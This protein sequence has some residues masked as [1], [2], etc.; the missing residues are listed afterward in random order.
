MLPGIFPEAIPVTHP[1]KR[2]TCVYP[3]TNRN[4]LKLGL[5]DTRCFAWVFQERRGNGKIETINKM[6][7]KESFEK[8]PSLPLD[9]F[10]NVKEFLLEEDYNNALFTSKQKLEYKCHVVL[11]DIIFKRNIHDPNMMS[12]FSV[13]SGFGPVPL[14]ELNFAKY[15]LCTKGN[16]GVVVMNVLNATIDALHG[17]KLHLI[18]NQYL[19]ASSL[20]QIWFRELESE[21]NFILFILK[22]GRL[23]LSKVPAK[24]KNNVSYFLKDMGKYSSEHCKLAEPL[25][26]MMSRGLKVKIIFETEGWG[27]RIELECNVDFRMIPKFEMK[28][29]I[30]SASSSSPSP[31][32]PSSSTSLSSQ[33]PSPSFSSSLQSPSPSSSSSS[34]LP[35]PSFSSTS[36]S[37]PPHNKKRRMF[38]DFFM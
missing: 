24:G 21:N 37:S 28:K 18:K 19:N 27:D 3:P 2:N 6:K 13:I 31:S 12:S 9:V 20:K 5:E 23:K 29:L 14:S 16:D 26:S 22:D 8:K 25:V 7:T 11:S 38:G 15:R 36:S 32:P 17:L 34:Q 10:E 33:S 35:S 4:P 30:A 1:I